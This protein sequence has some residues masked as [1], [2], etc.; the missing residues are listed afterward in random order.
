MKK[1][2]AIIGGGQTAEKVHV[3]YYLTREEVE[4]V[5][6]VGRNMERTKNFAIRN[7]I[8]RSYTD[9]DEMFQAEQ[10]DIVSVCTPNRYHYENVIKALEYGCHVMCEKPPAISAVEA[11]HMYEVANENNLILAYNFHHRFADDVNILRKKVTEGVLGDIYVVKAKALRRSGVP[12]WGDFI[13]KEAQGGGPLIDLGVHMLDAAL[14][15]LGYPKVE[16]V[17]AKMFQKIG[18]KK[19]HGSFGE[20]DPKK[21]EVEDSLF[22]F[23]EL[24]GGC[25]LQLETSFALN[26]K[27]TSIMNVEFCGDEAGATLFPASIYTDQKGELVTILDRK[28]ADPDRLQKGMAA[29]VDKCL[30]KEVMVANGREGHLILQLIE[31]LYQS[32]EKGESVTI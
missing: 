7:G 11:K 18:R 5:A 13:N 24:E 1:K 2:V 15:V 32:A 31:A 4:I 21:F 9:A 17:T 29:F 22:G 6:V 16:K 14:Y 23:I 12:G 25:L 27:E 10:P 28:T 8:D 30:G 20:W 3:P 26:I 19:S